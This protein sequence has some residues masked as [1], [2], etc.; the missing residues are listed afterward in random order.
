MTQAPPY[1]PPSLADQPTSDLIRLASTQI[2]IKVGFWG[3]LF[4]IVPLAKARQDLAKH[5]NR[6]VTGIFAAAQELTRNT[7]LWEKH[8][9]W[10]LEWSKAFRS[11]V[12]I[13]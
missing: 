5:W 3:V 8:V 2:Y 12:I 10:Q 7:E 1:A 11:F 4:V 6:P 9:K 13:A